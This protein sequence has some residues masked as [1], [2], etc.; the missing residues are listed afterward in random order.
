MFSVGFGSKW[1]SV[2]ARPLSS[3]NAQCAAVTGVTGIGAF[4]MFARAPARPGRRFTSR[5]ELP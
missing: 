3:G 1:S 5:K 2:I 4:Q